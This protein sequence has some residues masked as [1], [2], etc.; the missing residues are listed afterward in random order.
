[1]SIEE[2]YAAVRR[3]GLQATAIQTV[4]RTNAGDVYNVPDPR[5]YTA[6]QRTEIIQQL[7]TRM[8]VN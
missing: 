7:R 5:E 8:G 6:E 1:M 3:L 4:F 2:Y